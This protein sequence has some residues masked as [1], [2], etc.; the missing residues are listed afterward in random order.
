MEQIHAIKTH[1][2]RII[3]Y[4]NQRARKHVDK[5]KQISNLIKKKGK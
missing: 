5:S 4:L 1:F 2:K 3:E